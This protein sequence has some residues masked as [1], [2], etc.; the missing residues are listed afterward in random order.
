MELELTQYL[1]SYA[2]WMEP[3]NMPVAVNERTQSVTSNISRP[4]W[5]KDYQARMLLKLVRSSP[6]SSR[7]IIESPRHLLVVCSGATVQQQTTTRCAGCSLY[8]ETLYS[9]TVRYLALSTR[10]YGQNEL[11]LLYRGVNNRVISVYRSC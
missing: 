1:R 9:S 2:G 5:A 10:L 7:D 6:A 3:T 8:G 11:M 4:V